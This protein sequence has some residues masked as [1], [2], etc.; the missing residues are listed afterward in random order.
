MSTEGD[1]IVSWRERW[2]AVCLPLLL[3]ASPVPAADVD[4]ADPA[5]KRDEQAEQ[6]PRQVEDVEYIELH[7]SLAAL[8]ALGA[9][10]R[11]V[12]RAIGSSIS[13]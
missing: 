2:L 6:K 12:G 1:K 10:R 9:N 8:L 7:L 13:Q 4:A 5:E 3:L 11:Q